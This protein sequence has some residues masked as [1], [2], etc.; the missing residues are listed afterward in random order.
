MLNLLKRTD[1]TDAL[2]TTFLAQGMSRL[3]RQLRVPSMERAI[4]VPAT[5]ANMQT[6]QAPIDLLQVMDVFANNLPLEK[7]AFRQIMEMSAR[8]G[9]EW[10]S[11][12]PRYYARVGS[13]F[14]MFPSL[15]IGGTMVT[16]YYGELS[17]LPNDAASN[18]ATNGFPDL[19]VYAS[20]SFAGDYFRMDQRDDWEAAFQTLLTET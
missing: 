10:P 12:Q 14:F 17:D 13:N 11:G 15:A 18:E 7:K 6:F 9:G 1:C 4:T 5:L 19:L 16:T 20:L 3:Q 2:A 8:Y